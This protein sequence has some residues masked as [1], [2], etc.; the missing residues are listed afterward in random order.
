MPSRLRHPARSR[1]WVLAGIQGL[2]ALYCLLS[3]FVLSPGRTQPENDVT[4]AV[5]LLGLTLLTAVIV[6][7]RGDV[8]LHGVLASTWLVVAVL[9]AVRPTGQGQLVMG[10]FL[11]MLCMWIAGFLRT[12]VAVPHIVLACASYVVALATNPHTGSPLYASALLVAI[13]FASTMVL[14]GREARSRYVGLVRTSAD[15]V[16][17]TVRGQVVWVSPAVE[18]VL[19]WTPEEFISLPEPSWHRDD[20]KT[21]LRMREALYAGEPVAAT[22]RLRH[23]DGSYRWIEAR[24][25]PIAEDDAPPGA[26]GSLRDVTQRVEGELALADSAFRQRRGLKRMRR[27]DAAK[28]RMVHDL[29]HE[30]RTP[31][32]V[33]RGPLERHLRR[34]SGL[35]DDLRHDLEAAVRASRR[36]ERLVDDILEIERRAAQR[37]ETLA[38]A[39]VRTLTADA[40]ELVAPDAHG[41]GLTLHL[42]A[43]DAVP[44][45]VLADAEAWTLVVLNLVSNAVKYTDSG[46]VEVRLDYADESLVLAVEDTGRGIAEDELERIFDRFYTSGGRPSRGTGRSGLGLTLVADAVDAAGGHLDVSSVLGSGTTFVVTLPA[47]ACDAQTPA[48]PQPVVTSHTEQ[49]DASEPI[50]DALVVLM[51]GGRRSFE[52][53][54]AELRSRAGGGSLS[55]AASEILA[56][57]EDA[58]DVP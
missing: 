22:Y 32:T 1:Y 50:G 12:R 27:V 16:I 49:A 7:A 28:T 18:G 30:L 3:A 29:S 31:L 41:A 23:R 57:A 44:P 33:I 10:V 58:D 11:L 4:A 20:E 51:A 13:A 53:A 40:V 21:V 17:R 39:D 2:L 14:Y 15:V 46:G 52:Q 26:V 5:L 25:N 9:A 55:H 43:S 34:E 19:G 37:H 24:L 38:P 45:T 42:T 36:L 54:L 47:E 35:S 48:R 6:P 8:L 56:E